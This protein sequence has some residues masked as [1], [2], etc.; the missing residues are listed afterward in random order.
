VCYSQQVSC[1]LAFV[2]FKEIGEIM[3]ESLVQLGYGEIVSWKSP[4][5]CDYADIITSLT[6]RNLD[7]GVA[8]A[9]LPRNAFIRG[10]R[11]ME[12]KRIIRKVRE[13]SD[14]IVFQLNKIE[15]DASGVGF[16]YP[17][18]TEITLDKSSGMVSCPDSVLGASVQVLLNLEMGR[19]TSGDITK[20]V[21]T[22]FQKAGNDLIPIREHGGAYFVPAHMAH[23]VDQ[24]R[25]FLGDIGGEIRR[26]GGLSGDSTRE[27]LSVAIGSH[28]EAMIAEFHD[29]IEGLNTESSDAVRDRRSATL[30][31]LRFRLNSYRDLLQLSAE[32][33]DYQLSEAEKEMFARLN[34]VINPSQECSPVADD[35]VADDSEMINT[36]FGI[37]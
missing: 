27:A 31:D 18:E 32:E 6:S 5:E 10:V 29:T 21:Q 17:H 1:L 3:S 15:K 23:L 30:A 24:V 37:V 13:D 9:L 35:P 4:K 19:R 7:V 25:D 28:F 14:N 33:I 8:R 26:F 11:S 20:I 34:G 22:L 16:E 2:S 36:L 12:E